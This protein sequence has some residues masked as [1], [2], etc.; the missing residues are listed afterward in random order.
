[1]EIDDKIEA[2][3]KND[4]LNLVLKISWLRLKGDERYT[5]HR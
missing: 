2:K 5:S 1:M 4:Y 3:Y